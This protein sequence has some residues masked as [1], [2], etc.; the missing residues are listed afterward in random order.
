[1]DRGTGNYP[2]A[3]HQLLRALAIWDRLEPQGIEASE[4]LNGLGMVYLEEGRIDDAL[5]SFENALK[6]A[7]AAHAPSSSVAHL[8][9]NI[10]SL[11]FRAHRLATAE[12]IYQ[13]AMAMAES[14]LGPEHPLIGQI[15][16]NYAVVLRG[17]RKRALADKFE[18]RGLAILRS[19][20]ASGGA[21]TVDVSDLVR[22]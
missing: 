7:E 15:L 4:V 12:S 6:L 22:R 14:S 13:R 18:K 20:V 10:G 19:S 21:Y 5:L 1:V 8:L 16:F 2:K 3:E 9:V 11:H 17:S